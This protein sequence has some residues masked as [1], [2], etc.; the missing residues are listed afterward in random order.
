MQLIDDFRANY[1][2]YWSVWCHFAAGL[3]ATLGLME[4]LGISFLP[5]LQN[6]LPPVVFIALSILCTLAGLVA[7]GIKQSSLNPDPLPTEGDNADGNAQAS[8]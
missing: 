1:P 4:Q 7:R 3:L 6:S 8:Q 2:R 5:L